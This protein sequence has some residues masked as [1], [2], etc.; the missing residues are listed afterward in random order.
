MTMNCARAAQIAV[1]LSQRNRRWILNPEQGA[2]SAI[3]STLDAFALK[4]P[5]RLDATEIAVDVDAQQPCRTIAR[6]TGGR[7]VVSKAEDV[8]ASASTKA[9]IAPADYDRVASVGSDC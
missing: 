3:S 2:W 7:G 8:L 4:P 9:S 6:P 5:A 1:P